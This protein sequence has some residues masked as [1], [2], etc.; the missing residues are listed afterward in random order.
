MEDHLKKLREEETGEVDDDDGAGWENWDVETDSS[1]SESESGGWIDVSSEGGDL[2]V[3]DSEDE[4][5][6]PSVRAKEPDEDA[7]RTSTLAT[8]KVRRMSLL[9]TKDVDGGGRF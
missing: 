5:E 4:K 6:A 8:T 9:P 3:S 7:N 2:E 1:D